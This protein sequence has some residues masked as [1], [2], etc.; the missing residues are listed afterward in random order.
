MGYSRT[1]E[2]VPSY[3]ITTDLLH[4]NDPEKLVTELVYAK[5]KEI[6]LIQEPYP[7]ASLQFYIDTY[8]IGGNTVKVKLYRN[9]VA[10]GAEHTSNSDGTW[11]AFTDDIDFTDLAIDDTFEI[12]GYRTGGILGKVRNF[13]VYAKET[14]FYNTLE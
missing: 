7:F 13:R 11:A 5:V 2:L 14:P 3:A 1:V 4:S 8:N 10:I 12:W 9:G 6:Q